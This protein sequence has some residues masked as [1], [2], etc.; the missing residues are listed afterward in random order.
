MNVSFVSSAVQ[1]VT[2]DGGYEETKIESQESEAVNRRNAHRPL[3]DQ[4]R[5]NQEEE[6][7]RQEEQQREMMRGTLALDEDDVAHLDAIENQRAERDRAIQEQTVSE[8]AAFRAARALRREAALA[9]ENDGVREGD[10]G[11]VGE[12]VDLAT[13]PIEP[14][15]VEGPIG[16]TKPPEPRP[17]LIK[18]KKRKRRTSP[19]G[20]ESATVERKDASK[21]ASEVADQTDKSTS[22]KGQTSKAGGGLDDLLCGYGSTDESE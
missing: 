9:D 11:G 3:F 19:D 17:P 15:P 5:A 13:V 2:S 14:G 18:V 8:L 7:A 10:E 22:E 1:T 16:A 21:S 6:Q 4:L 12:T 20:D